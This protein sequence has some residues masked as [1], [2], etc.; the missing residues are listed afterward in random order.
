VMELTAYLDDPQP[1]QANHVRAIPGR[2]TKVPIWLLGS[3]TYSAQLAAYLGRPFA[4]ASHF[5]P[6]LLMQ[7]LEI[8]RESYRP[9]AE[10]PKPHAMVGLNVIAADTD[11]EAAFHYTSIQQRFLGMVRGVRG[12][13]PR[14]VVSMDGLWNER[15]RAQVERM[16][17]V[18]VVGSPDTVRRGLQ[19]LAERTGAD[20]LI[21]AGAMHDHAARLRSYALTAQCREAVATA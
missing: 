11:D 7:A 3:S 20:E 17:A 13:L 16:L 8:Y 9:S 14:P 5:A 2:G 18:S 6:D 10:W 12:P 15:E 4:F 1:G 19:A 21:I